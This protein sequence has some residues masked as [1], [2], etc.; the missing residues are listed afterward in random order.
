MISCTRQFGPGEKLQVPRLRCA[1]LGMTRDDTG[2][3]VV[4]HAKAGPSLRSG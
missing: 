2:R 1:S 4:G 3:S